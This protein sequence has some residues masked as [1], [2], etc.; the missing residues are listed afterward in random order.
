ERVV[1]ALATLPDAQRI[2]VELA[3]FNGLSQR[4][5]AAHLREP[6]GTIKTRLRLGI[7]KLK[8]ALADERDEFDSRR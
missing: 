2:A 8:D 7:H 4:E 5:I 3:Y 1:V 6:L